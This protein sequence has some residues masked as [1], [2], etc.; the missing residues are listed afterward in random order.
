MHIES[1]SFGKIQIDGVAYAKDVI[2]V[3]DRVYSPWWRTAGGHV[4]APVDLELVISAAP[5]VVCLGTGYFGRVRVDDATLAAFEALGT[6]LE[7]DRT[8]PIAE[9]FN[10]LAGVGVDVAAALHLTC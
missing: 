6:D 10:E 3:G 2:L 7:I 9:R 1:Y 5:R 8:G 4:F